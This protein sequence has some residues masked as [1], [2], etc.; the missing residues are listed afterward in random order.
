M[1]GTANIT[2]SGGENTCQIRNI[3]HGH[4]KSEIEYGHSLLLI[5]YIIIQDVNATII[6]GCQITMLSRNCGQIWNK[7]KESLWGPAG[8]HL[9]T[10]VGFNVC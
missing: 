2:M 8:F 7:K 5:N 3:P 9:R 10:V 6:W 1:V 4:F